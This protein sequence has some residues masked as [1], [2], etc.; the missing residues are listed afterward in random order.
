MA[1]N[2]CNTNR[3]SDRP[4][5]LDTFSWLKD[6]PDT[7]Y[8]SDL[9]EIRF[10]GTRKGFFRNE[11]GLRLERDE[12]VVVACNSGH[13]VGAVSL[14]GRLADLQFK[15]KVKHHDLYPTKKIYRKATP[16]DVIK[17]EEAK[18]RENKVMIRARQIANELGLTMKIGDVEFQGDNTKAIFYYIADGRVD[19]RELIKVF[20]S[21]FLV[22]IEMMQI[23]VRQEAGLIGG[24]GSCGR[25][26]CCSTWLTDFTSIVS[27]VA[28][29]QGLS[30]N[31]ERLTGR[32][33]RLKCCLTYELDQYLEAMEDF[34]NELLT[35]ET[36]K[37]IATH[38]KTDII[39]RKIW[40]KLDHA[41][42]QSF[43]LDLATVI[44]FLNLNKR[45]IKPSVDDYS[46]KEPVQGNMMNVGHLDQRLF[47]KQVLTKK[48]RHNKHRPT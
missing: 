30:P 31:A 11:S 48:P 14:T 18:S 46:E 37:G 33:G 34:P 47:A 17:W 5:M 43:V 1:C 22:K 7:S 10:K 27:D 29:K 2:I 9:V 12:L 40:Y 28:V 42:G 25:S 13:D 16:S 4:A 23:G 21:E 26:L 38:L 8:E 44:E 19:F 36:S 41:A 45:G 20:S 32:C 35:I 39:Q 3:D 6:L 15:R 24:I